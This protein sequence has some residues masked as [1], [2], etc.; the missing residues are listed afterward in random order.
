MEVMRRGYVLCFGVRL[1]R[2]KQNNNR[3]MKA[4]VIAETEAPMPALRPVVRVG[5][6]EAVG[7]VGTLVIATSLAGEVVKVGF[8]VAVVDVVSV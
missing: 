7:L 4:R 3:P 5:V 1:R 8:C 2:R 6:A